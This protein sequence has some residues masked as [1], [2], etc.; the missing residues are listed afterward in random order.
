MQHS[1]VD[2]EQ[3]H[4]MLLRL[5]R[6]VHHSKHLSLIENLINPP[7]LF[8][9]RL[10]LIFACLFFISCS[11]SVPHRFNHYRLIKAVIIRLLDYY[12]QF[13]HEICINGKNSFDF[14]SF[15]F[16]LYFHH[17]FPMFEI[18]IMTRCMCE[19]A[20]VC[21]QLKNKSMQKIPWIIMKK[22]VWNWRWNQR[23]LNRSSTFT[24]EERH[25]QNELQS[26]WWLVRRWC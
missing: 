3:I 19:C 20:F 16:S 18:I 15:F 26:W 25:E 8:L 11:L 13:K 4:A 5:Q 7:S 17:Q 23:Q 1:V 22:I 6:W 21:V 2:F 14:L 10:L 9:F 24:K 12:L